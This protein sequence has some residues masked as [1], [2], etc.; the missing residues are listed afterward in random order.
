VASPVLRPW[1]RQFPFLWGLTP[2]VKAGNLE[3]SF[4]C[5]EFGLRPLTARI[6]SS[7]YFPWR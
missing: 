5:L 6:G 7:V 4:R 3:L 1:S 2:R